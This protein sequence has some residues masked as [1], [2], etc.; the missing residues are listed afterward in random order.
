MNVFVSDPSSLRDLQ[1]FLR[2]ANCVAEECRPNRLEVHVPSASNDGRARRHVN[3]YLATWQSNHHGVETY[4]IEQDG[5]DRRVSAV[6]T[7]F[8]R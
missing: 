8:K 2:R 4:I 5:S 7:R 3:I 6:S 1:E